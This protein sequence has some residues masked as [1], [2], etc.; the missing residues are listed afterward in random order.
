MVRPT[1][2]LEKGEI[3][4][5][6]LEERASVYRDRTMAGFKMQFKESKM[7]FYGTVVFDVIHKSLYRLLRFPEQGLSC[8]LAE[9]HPTNRLSSLIFHAIIL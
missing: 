6:G 8:C 2:L 3:S 4:V 1:K 9:Q 5:I 7:M